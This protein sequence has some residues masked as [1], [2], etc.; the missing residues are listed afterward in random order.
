MGKNNNLK[1]LIVHNYYKIPGGEGTVV[2]N[3][4]KLL[5]QNGHTVYLYTRNNNEKL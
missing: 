4:K 3:E 2:E 1:I 5:E